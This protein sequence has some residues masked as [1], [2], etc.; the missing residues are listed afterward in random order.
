[1]DGFGQLPDLPLGQKAEWGGEN[2]L[3]AP[4]FQ[5]GAQGIPVLL[6]KPAKDANSGIV[7]LRFQ[8]T[9]VDQNGDD[10]PVVRRVLFQ[11]LQE[12]P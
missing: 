7:L 12:T 9:A 3:A 6:A 5:D 4:N 2:C 8:K 1:M 10:R 11:F